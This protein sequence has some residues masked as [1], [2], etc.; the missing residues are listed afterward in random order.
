MR[1][2]TP[3]S[4]KAKKEKLQAQRALKTNAQGPNEL[5]PI[6][7][8]LSSRI[9]S[10]TRHAS[11]GRYGSL[12]EQRRAEARKSARSA[13]ESRFIKLSPAVQE[14]YKG[15]IAKR[16]FD[17]PIG[18]ERGCLLETDLGYH[19]VQDKLFCPKRPKWKYHM[20][21]KEVEKVEKGW[22]D[23]STYVQPSLRRM[24][25]SCLRSG[26]RKRMRSSKA[27]RKRTISG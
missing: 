19:I 23:L 3:Q 20:L 13:L 11:T 9:S 7:A 26:S 6:P 14:H 17:R 24:R 12:E 1:R 15:V 10:T 21:K 22:V 16:L 2:R 27:R 4:G 18:H 8:K 5:P 25:P